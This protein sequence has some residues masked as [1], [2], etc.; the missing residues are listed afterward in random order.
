MTDA[1]EKTQRYRG[2]VLTAQGKQKLQTQIQTLEQQTR[3][4]QTPKTIA[5]QVQLQ[6]PEGI[7]PM[8]VRKVLK[9]VGGVDKSSIQRIFQTLKLELEQADYVHAKL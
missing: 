8:T 1:R 3:M 9:G 2:F 4:R 5:E 7:H 6:H